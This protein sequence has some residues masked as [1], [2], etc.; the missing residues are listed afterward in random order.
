MGSLLAALNVAAD[1]MRT[2]QR[3]IDVTSNNVMNAKTPGYAKQSLQMLAR[4]LD[5]PGGLGGGLQ[6]GI[7]ISYRDESYETAVQDAAHDYGRASQRSQIL[8]QVEPVF[9]ISGNTGIGAA[10]DKFFE[11]FSLLSVNPNDNATRRSVIDRAQ[12]L[13]NQFRFADS[14]LGSADANA[15]GQL[16]DK[17]S[18]INRIGAQI[19]DYNAKVQQRSASASDA[20]L[21]AQ[22]HQ[23]MEELA[24]LADFDVIRR[25]DDTL[26]ISLGGQTPLVI[27]K[28]L[29]A[30][31]VDST[32]KVMSGTDDIGNQ[33]Q[34]GEIKGVL[35]VRQQVQDLRTGLSDLATAFAGQVNSS[36]AAGLDKN[37]A[38]PAR[39]LFQISGGT[40]T[41]NSAFT[42]DDVAAASAGAPG[43]NGNAL[44]LA[45]LGTAKTIGTLT[46]SQA[47]G[48]IASDVGGELE[49]SR[50]EENTQQ[51][52]L[53]QAKT[54]RQDAQ[55]VSLDEEAANLMAFQRG[56]QA[57][58]EVVRILNSL[59]ET[60]INLLR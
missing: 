57:T 52:L 20:G 58:A 39:D 46:F 51:L 16:K 38:T 54:L 2:M 30:L 18:A 17:V 7:Q 45:A 53:S 34:S 35:E 9:D 48:R 31:S 56:Y 21:D 43:G 15:L 32:G 41:V 22:V 4:Q 42:T 10:L 25:E 1:S 23:S 3:A 59:T 55:G 29:N 47:Y 19:Q 5:L 14:S 27:G 36:L 37:G 33:F 8:S 12:D 49:Q 50:D 28:T 6:S 60:T 40:L 11:G 26:Q 44:S 24:A 13:A